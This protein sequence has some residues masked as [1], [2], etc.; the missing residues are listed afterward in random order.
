MLESRPDST[1]EVTDEERRT[2][3]KHEDDWLNAGPAVASRDQTLS[4]PYV[5]G[6]PIANEDVRQLANAVALKAGSDKSKAHL[7]MS[8][9][10]G[11][12][13]KPLIA[14]VFV[15][16]LVQVSVM[17]ASFFSSTCRYGT[18]KYP[19]WLWIPLLAWIA[20]LLVCESKCVSFA[21]IA[22]TQQT[23]PVKPFCTEDCNK[24]RFAFSF[25]LLNLLKSSAVQHITTLTPCLF[26]GS[27]LARRL[28][29]TC[30]SKEAEQ[31]WYSSL[32][33]S[34]VTDRAPM[35]LIVLIAW[36]INFVPTVYT[37]CKTFPG[38]AQWYEGGQNW[39]KEGTQYEQDLELEI[40][41]FK[42]IFKKDEDVAESQVPCKYGDKCKY[43][44]RGCRYAHPTR[45]R[46]E[47]NPVTVLG[48]MRPKGTRYFYYPVYGNL[49]LTG[50]AFSML[51]EGLGMAA[52]ET[53]GTEHAESAAEDNAAGVGG[54]AEETCSREDL[55]RSLEI[56]KKCMQHVH[57][58]DSRLKLR[59]I[60]TGILSC[61]LQLHLQISTMAIN[62]HLHKG[63]HTKEGW[64]AW[65][66]ILSAFSVGFF[67]I[68][69]LVRNVTLY[70]KPLA[71]VDKLER[72]A[73][74]VRGGKV[75]EDMHH[76]QDMRRA[77]RK[78]RLQ[79]W[80]LTLLFWFFLAW[81]VCKMIMVHR[82]EH[83][84]WNLPTAVLH[85]DMM[86]GCVDLADLDVALHVR[87]H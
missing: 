35:W 56:A 69:A 77:L 18:M 62:T 40:V 71:I 84:L 78:D 7:S 67:V 87:H 37:L 60:V 46:G 19:S 59:I 76:I 2:L 22:F 73:E 6:I 86:A 70:L 64:Q 28:S 54:I 38:Y 10:V 30:F 31:I 5:L 82:C 51:G 9:C 45:Q 41:E 66:A 20:F 12:T 65:L 33:Q 74:K 27:V 61:G 43:I 68:L 24:S 80:A 13:L 55:R 16:A 58:N 53:L 52:L 8:W 25:W 81:A 48:K 11:P 32:R 36:L 42:R 47:N 44:G 85:L 21:I 26:A 23:G 50:S 15:S 3:L 75:E 1:F 83:S 72:M 34:P 63:D 14:L 79:I 39:Q 17:L 49:I 57:S 4:E 29:N